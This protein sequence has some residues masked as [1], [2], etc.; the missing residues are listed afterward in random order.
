MTPNNQDAE[1]LSDRDESEN[2]HEVGLSKKEGYVRLGGIFLTLG[3]MIY[4]L[5]TGEP[6]LGL[7]VLGTAIGIVVA[8]TEDGREAA[9][10]FI[11]EV[12][13]NQ[14]QE[15]PKSVQQQICTQCGWQNPSAN[16][17]CF[18]CGSEL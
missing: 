18:D 8:F 11:E 6:F 10:V 14:Q 2:L 1:E 13:E 7:L 12:K 3:L 9:E 15:S 16:N 4:F 17:Y 5:V